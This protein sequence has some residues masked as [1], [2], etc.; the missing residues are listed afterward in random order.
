MEY[1]CCC[2]FKIKDYQEFDR[3]S[4]LFQALKEKM[5]SGQSHKSCHEC[6]RLEQQGLF[7]ERLRYWLAYDS[8]KFTNLTKNWHNDCFEIKIKFSNLCPLSCRSCSADESSTYSKITGI[9]TS[10]KHIEID[11]SEHRDHWQTIQKIITDAHKTYRRPILHLIGGEAL[12]Q[13]GSIKLLQWMEEN[14]LSDKFNF[15][16]TTS[17]AV[18]LKD[19]FLGLIEHFQHVCF[20][21]S[22]DSVGNNYHYVRWPAKFDKVLLNLEKLIKTRSKLDSSYIFTPVFSLNNVFYIEEYLNFFQNWCKEKNFYIPINNLHLHSP[23]H[24]QIEILPEK[25]RQDLISIF[26]KC[27]EHPW[28]KHSQQDGFKFFLISSLEHLRQSSGDEALFQKFLK[29]TAE[30]DVRTQTSF[31]E[32]NSKLYN[33]LSSDH[34]EIYESQYQSFENFYNKKKH[35]LCY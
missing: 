10:F 26:E 18:N 11:I 30:F 12:I 32:F 2:N 23:D 25:Y 22:I 15:N 35:N 24:L 13:P 4:S 17:L 7:S 1:S 28:S 6:Y 16:L 8:E 19:K 9:S 5:I 33:L 3:E 27:I 34:L 29:F 20:S 14:S 31:K 21:L